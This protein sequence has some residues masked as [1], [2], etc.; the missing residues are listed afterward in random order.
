MIGI[1]TDFAYFSGE[2]S[3]TLSNYTKGALLY[4]VIPVCALC[5][6]EQLRHPN[7]WDVFRRCASEQGAAPLAPVGNTPD[8]TENCLMQYKR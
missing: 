4:G 1:R 6:T 7:V 3:Y 2:R 5:E 8:Y